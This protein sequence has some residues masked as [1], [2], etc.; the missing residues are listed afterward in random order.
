L[1]ACTDLAASLFRLPEEVN[2]ALASNF[3]RAAKAT[4]S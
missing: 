2:A 1:L 4:S 3:E